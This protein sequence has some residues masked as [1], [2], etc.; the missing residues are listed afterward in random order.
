MVLMH[1]YCTFIKTNRK[2]GL[3]CSKMFL[4]KKTFA[5]F[6]HRLTY[7]LNRLNISKSYS[8]TTLLTK[9]ASSKIFSFWTEIQNGLIDV[10]CTTEADYT[11]LKQ[12]LH[13]NGNISQFELWSESHPI[14]KFLSDMGGHTVCKHG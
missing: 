13:K 5:H 10:S 8:H 1:M 14:G 7:I 12:Q 9:H 6:E 2:C 4:K 3:I 11:V